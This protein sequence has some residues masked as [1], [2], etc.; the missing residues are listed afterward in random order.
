MEAVLKEAST[1]KGILRRYYA[2][3]LM[4]S[5]AGGFLFGVYPI[6]LKSRGLTQFQINSVLATYFVTLFHRRAD[7]RVRGCTRKAALVRA[8]NAAARDGVHRLF[9]CAS[10]LRVPHRGEHRR[11]RYHLLQRRDRCVGRRRT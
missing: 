1:I 6:F 11:Y 5:F 4:Y 3:W 2:V 9:L 8:G 7:G 10:L